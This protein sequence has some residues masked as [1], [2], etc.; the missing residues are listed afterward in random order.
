LLPIKFGA[1]HQ[2]LRGAVIEV[3]DKSVKKNN[4]A[5]NPQPNRAKVN[6]TTVDLDPAMILAAVEQGVTQE[7]PILRTRE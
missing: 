3:N 6:M 2:S 4:L 7:V 1:D 5:A